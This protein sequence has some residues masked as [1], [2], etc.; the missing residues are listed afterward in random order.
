MVSRPRWVRALLDAA[1]LDEV[2]RAV[3]EAE[4]GTSGE[5]RV[6]L[7][8]RVPGARDPG[9][10][11]VLGR[12]RDVFA[13]LGMTRT[14]ERNAVLIYLATDDHRLAI[15][16]DEGVHARV[17]DDYWSRIRDAMVTRL[18]QGHARAAL[19]EAVADVGRVL[20]EHFPRRPD[21]VDELPD[22]PSVG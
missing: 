14:R 17:G 2:A 11:A 8:R 22:R 13:H 10:G 3:H 4:A 16:G 9:D 12:A 18:R 15:V 6:H 21:D 20:G 5:I 7:E 1:D 19:V